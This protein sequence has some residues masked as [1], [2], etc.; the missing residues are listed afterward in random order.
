MQC[1]VTQATLCIYT[2]VLPTYT[3][4]GGGGEYFKDWR[5]ER[6]GSPSNW[7]TRKKVPNAITASRFSLYAS[8]M[9]RNISLRKFL[10]FVPELLRLLKSFLLLIV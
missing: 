1:N 7:R 10:P 9:E 2:F 8:L 3:L 4:G 5:C 6:H